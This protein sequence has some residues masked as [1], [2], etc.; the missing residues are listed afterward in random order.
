VLEVT[1][2]HPAEQQ[3]RRINVTSSDESSSA[4]VDVGS[5]SKQAEISD[6]GN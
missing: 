1:V 5:G 2:P 6:S 3:P 4:T